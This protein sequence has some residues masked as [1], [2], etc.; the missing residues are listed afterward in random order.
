M[1]STLAFVTSCISSKTGTPGKFFRKT[2]WQ[3]RSFS[4]SRTVLY[5]SASAAKSKPPI[6][7]NSDTWVFT[8]SVHLINR[9]AYYHALSE[10]A[11]VALIAVCKGNVGLGVLARIPTL[12]PSVAFVTLHHSLPNISLVSGL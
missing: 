3:N 4:T 7:E 9:L 10:L 12:G 11:I 5:P 1:A 2:F 8:T 6:P